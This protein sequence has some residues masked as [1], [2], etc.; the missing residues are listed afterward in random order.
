[1]MKSQSLQCERVIADLA[2][3]IRDKTCNDISVQLEREPLASNLRC[4]IKEV[5]QLSRH[6]ASTPIAKYYISSVHDV[7][8][9]RNSGHSNTLT[10]NLSEAYESKI[11]TLQS[12]VEILRE[13]NETR[14]LEIRHLRLI[15]HNSTVKNKEQA[16]RL[17]VVPQQFHT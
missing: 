7:D 1:M 2:Q 9:S 16:S 10:A 6:F 12:E 3:S 14:E 4:V 5:Q 17:L 11:R 13:E 15:T 8:S